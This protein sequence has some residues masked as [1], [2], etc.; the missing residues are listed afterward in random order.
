VGVGRRNLG[1]GRRNLG[2]GR[3]N[4]GSVAASWGSVAVGSGVGLR[5][6]RAG[7]L[8]GWAGPLTHVAVVGRVVWAPCALARPATALDV[9]C[10]L[11]HPLRYDI[12]I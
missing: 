6:W 7:G 2:V 5:E 1:V 4:L 11:Y 3:R 9:S 10:G 8:L 12:C